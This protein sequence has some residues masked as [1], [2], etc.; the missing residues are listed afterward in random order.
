MYV[1]FIS[2][3]CNLKLE[4]DRI[5]HNCNRANDE[6]ANKLAI[7]LHVALHLRRKIDFEICR[8]DVLMFSPAAINFCDFCETLARVCGI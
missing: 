8:S 1:S 5:S 7:Y 6:Y 2:Q 4:K 3:S